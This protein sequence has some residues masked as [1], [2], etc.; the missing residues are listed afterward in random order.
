MIVRKGSPTCAGW[1]QRPERN[2]KTKKNT[3]ATALAIVCDGVRATST[4]PSA[5]ISA[6]ESRSE[7][8]KGRICTWS[9]APTRKAPIGSPT[10][11][12]SSRDGQSRWAPNNCSEGVLGSQLI[13]EPVEG[14]DQRA[15]LISP[16]TALASWNV[17]DAAVRRVGLEVLSMQQAKILDVVRHDCAPVTR[18]RRQHPVVSS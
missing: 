16:E 18:G 7:T 1:T 10:H 2:I 9:D 4:R 6:I 15:K 17:H 8:P 14:R 3:P 13:Q 5:N 12:E 11:G